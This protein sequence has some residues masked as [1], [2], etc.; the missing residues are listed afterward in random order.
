MLLRGA[1]LFGV[2]LTSGPLPTVE[3]CLTCCFA[4][5]MVLVEV[6]TT[7]VVKLETEVLLV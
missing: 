2:A 1:I 5:G 4:A 6:V 3:T 7:E